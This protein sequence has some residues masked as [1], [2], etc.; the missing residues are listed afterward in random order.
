MSYANIASS[1]KNTKPRGAY[2]K[3]ARDEES[4]ANPLLDTDG[5]Q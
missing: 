4:G 3:V 2:T 5:Q 1:N